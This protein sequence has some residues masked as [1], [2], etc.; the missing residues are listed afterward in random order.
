VCEDTKVK[1][2]QRYTGIIQ[3]LNTRFV[4]QINI[5]LINFEHQ[6]LNFDELNEM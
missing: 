4:L 3:L 5:V 1:H 6:A 2:L